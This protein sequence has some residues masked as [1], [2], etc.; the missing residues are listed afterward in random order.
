[1]NI[2]KNIMLGVLAVYTIFILMTILAHREK[3]KE[4][5]IKFEEVKTRTIATKTKS[6]W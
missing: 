6:M 4:L 1:M 3:I 5:E 2:Q